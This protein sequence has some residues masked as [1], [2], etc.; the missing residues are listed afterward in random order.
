ML[1]A[2]SLRLRFLDKT[3]MLSTSGYFPGGNRGSM[4]P[5]NCA[6]EP[7]KQATFMLKPFRTLHFH[8]GDLEL[9][10]AEVISPYDVIL[11]ASFNE[12]MTL[13]PLRVMFVRDRKARRQVRSWLRAGAMPHAA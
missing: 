2:M 13:L 11:R 8:R 7:R 5:V 10:R 4:T 12:E 6:R 1:C 3:P 9:I